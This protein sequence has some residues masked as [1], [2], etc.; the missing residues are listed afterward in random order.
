MQISK[1]DFLLGIQIINFWQALES[2]LR[3]VS[4]ENHS[5]EQL[6][7]T[8]ETERSAACERAAAAEKEIEKKDNL[9][10]ELFG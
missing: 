6:L 5:I 1:Y 3:E 8:K 7:A 2:K 4:E 10:K 9:L